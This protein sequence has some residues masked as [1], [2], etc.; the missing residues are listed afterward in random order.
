MKKTFVLLYILSQMQYCLAQG[1]IKRRNLINNS[2]FEE[3]SVLKNDRNVRNGN[4]RL[5]YKTKLAASGRYSQ[6]KKTGV[7]NFY[8]GKSKVIQ[9]FD[10]D[11]SK[12]ITNT[13]ECSANLR[14]EIP[15]ALDGDSIINPVKI[16]GMIAGYQMLARKFR[17]LEY[18]KERVPFLTVSHVFELDSAGNLTSWIT[19]SEYSGKTKFD[20]QDIDQLSA[21]ERIFLPAFVNGKRVPSA[22][23][24]NDIVHIKTSQ[25]LKPR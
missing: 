2:F 10:Y 7:W 9:Q 8:D 21:D 19:R 14:F 25:K 18:E 16:G 17:T 24:F 1:T 20:R 13:D 4:Y 22:V 6:G 15:D 11:N 12:L 3:Y 5:L 23:I